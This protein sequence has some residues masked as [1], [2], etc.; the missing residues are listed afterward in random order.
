M[1]Y[2]RLQNEKSPYLLQHAQNPVDWY[3]WGEEA[4]EKARREDKPIFLSI[5]YSTCHWCHVM[6]RESF[7]D[8]EVAE[9]LNEAF[10][11]IKV[12]REERPD[13]DAVY[14]KI[15]QIMTQSGGW[16]LT[17]M[18]TPDQKPFFAA[19]YIPR[20]TRYGHVGL[21]EMIPEVK[22]LWQTKRAD[23]ISASLE[24][25]QALRRPT[26][27]K[28]GDIGEEV[29]HR[30]YRSLSM[31]FDKT[32]GGFGQAPKFPSPHNLFFLLR[33]WKRT[34][35]A[36]ALHMVE[37]TL[38]N[39]RRGG[40]YD[41]IGFGFHRYSTDARWI[42]P[43]FE[44]MLYDQ[45]LMAMA[46]IELFQ[47]TGK[48]EYETSAREIFSYVL[49]DLTDVKGG[50]Y[51]AEDA[52]S[53]GVEGKFYIWTE[54]EIRSVLTKNESDLF[55]SHYRHDSDI[56]AQGMQEIPVGH[57][58]PHLKPS[59]GG[60]AGDSLTELSD[61]MADIRKKLFAVREKRAHP[62]KDD[63]ILSDWNG[64]MIAALARGAQ[65][66]D[67]PTYAKAALRAMDFIFQSLQ[68]KE[69]RLLHRFRDGQGAI[70]ANIDDYSFIVWALL[71]LYEATFDTQHLF[72][73]LAYQSHLFGYF[74]DDQDGG[75]FFTPNDA[76]ELLT[77]PKELYDGAIPSGNSLA[78]INT[79]R[80]SR[81]T[82][83]AEM[84]ERAHEIYRAFCAEVDA[85]P[86]AFTQFLCGLDFAIGPASEVIIAGTMD[87]SDTKALLT[88][89]RRSFVP[90][91]IVIFRPEESSA[92]PDIEIIAPHVQPHQSIN[93]KTTAYICSNFTCE[94]PTND[95]VQMMDLLN[96]K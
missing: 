18:M 90:N 92:H 7:E 94:L 22:S 42:V 6:E 79:L 62:H 85:M 38:Q 78:F 12:D 64:L 72:K 23:V 25:T 55:L 13:I 11:N 50:F 73:A 59:S 69:G 83:D 41:Q 39:M 3:P 52:D 77:R 88:A 15:C 75:F 29:L 58:I 19:T 66:F 71:E 17:I 10:V 35:E 30:A 26:S 76:E 27:D 89:L 86:T 74:R 46:Y 8:E 82:G 57:F 36:Q 93:G 61:K 5:G 84:D 51:C 81:F 24:I 80:L 45:A 44:K 20:E 16:P 32:L 63:K 95:P 87:H 53:E 34:G 28:A 37:Q 91:T 31:S 9:L 40:I 49:R 14:M 2:N 67:E 48:K 65:V 33:Y 21:L 43:H 96:K 54:E 70:A 68:T 47:A 4:F 56:S 60:D 1:P